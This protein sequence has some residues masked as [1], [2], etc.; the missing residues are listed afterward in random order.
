[1][2]AILKFIFESLINGDPFSIIINIVKAMRTVFLLVIS[3]FLYK[4][5]V[6]DFTLSKNVDE[7]WNFFSTGYFL[8]P[9]AMLIVTWFLFDLI[10]SVLIKWIFNILLVNRMRNKA[11]RLMSTLAMLDTAQENEI[12]DMSNEKLTAILHKIPFYKQYTTVSN[13]VKLPKLSEKSI[14]NIDGVAL[15]IT[16]LIVV[17]FFTNMQS[18]ILV[19]LLIIILLIIEA[20]KSYMIS[21][22]IYNE[23]LFSKFKLIE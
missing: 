12:M 2:E 6:S 11:T 5:F 17:L 10:L 14:D 9:F 8:K 22:K 23:K 20:I 3:C 15:L 1:M 16:Q 19:T 21:Y 13:D 18:I 4:H 7:V